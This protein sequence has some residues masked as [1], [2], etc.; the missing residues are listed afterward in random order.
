MDRHLI[1]AEQVFRVLHERLGDAESIKRETLA[2]V[3][4][5]FNN[6]EFGSL[7][8]V[9][10]GWI[11]DGEQYCF[12]WRSDWPQ[13]VFY[14]ESA[15]EG[16][17]S[18]IVE[19]LCGPGGISDPSAQEQID[20]DLAI[21]TSLSIATTLMRMEILGSDNLSDLTFGHAYEILY[22]DGREFRYVSDVLYLVATVEFDEDGKFIAEELTGPI[23]KYRAFGEYSVTERFDPLN[24]HIDCHV[25]TPVGLDS[26]SNAN[27]PLQSLK[28]GYRSRNNQFPAASSFYCIFFRFVAPGFTSPLFSVV[29][30]GKVPAGQAFVGIDDDG[31]L[32]YDFRN[33]RI[34]WMYNTIRANVE[35]SLK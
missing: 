2:K 8:V 28:A 24:K 26:T 19:S 1:A 10:I 6:S 11:M 7:N 30:P 23:Y 13:E 29:Q 16:S 12:R 14:P 35:K 27:E 20:L 31:N 18:H 34:Q 22:F 3:L 21:D 25:I 17:G 9:L 4:T 33:S 5:E 32:T 15:Y